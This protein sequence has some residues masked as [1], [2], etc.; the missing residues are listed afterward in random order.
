MAHEVIM[1]A[2][3]MA[4]ETGVLVR[5]L[6]APG[7]RV[8]KGTPLIEVETD[9]AVQEVEAQAS[10]ILGAV[11]AEAGDEVPVGQVIGLI[12]AEGEAGAAGPAPVTSA[13]ASAGTGQTDTAAAAPIGAPKTSPAAPKPAHPAPA[14]PTSAAAP[15]SP[16]VGPPTS[17]RLLAS[18]KARRLAAEQGLD[19]AN[20]AKAGHPQP[21]HV[22]DLAKCSGG[23]GARTQKRRKRARGSHLLLPPMAGSRRPATPPLWT[24]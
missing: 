6:A 23:W 4:Q 11:S 7:D 1:P 3:G 17:G 22:K 14:A 9:K 21:Y 5:W 16:P 2:L 13:K 18:P 24:A 10:G 8:T 19:L 15:V 12:F 20:L